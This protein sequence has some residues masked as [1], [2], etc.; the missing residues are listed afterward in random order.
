MIITPSFE[1][2]RIPDQKDAVYCVVPNMV[3]P[4][5]VPP[6]RH[7]FNAN[8]PRLFCPVA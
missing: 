8:I 3:N 7:R 4:L 2:L 6:S 5:S 1:T